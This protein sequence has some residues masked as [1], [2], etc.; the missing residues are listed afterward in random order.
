MELAKRSAEKFI[1]TLR[2][3]ISWNADD[4]KK[5]SDNGTPMVMLR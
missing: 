2:M 5:L 4:A 3:T 1:R